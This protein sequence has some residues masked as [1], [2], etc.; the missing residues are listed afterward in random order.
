MLELLKTFLVYCW[1]SHPSRASPSL[2]PSRSGQEAGGSQH[3]RGRGQHP[4]PLGREGRLRAP[5]FLTCPRPRPIVMSGTFARSPAGTGLPGPGM[6]HRLR[7]QGALA[8]QSPG[9]PNEARAAAVRCRDPGGSRGPDLRPREKSRR[10]TFLCSPGPPLREGPHARFWGGPWSWAPRKRHEKAGI[11]GSEL[12]PGAP[13][14]RSAGAA[15]PGEGGVGLGPCLRTRQRPWQYRGAPRRRSPRGRRGAPRPR[16]P[17]RPPIPT[18]TPHGKP[19]GAVACFPG[20]S[21]PGPDTRLHAGARGRDGGALSPLP[22]PPPRAGPP[23]PP[24]RSPI[25]PTRRPPAPP[26]LS[27]SRASGG[28]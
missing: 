5:R 27:Q 24:P 8:T 16:S 25:A 4:T 17:A 19:F 12:G 18:P 11:P 7:E 3:V 23:P 1:G 2:R 10:G 6:R 13:H 15:G 22:T 20:G 28:V 21:P 26:L 14:Q 9:P